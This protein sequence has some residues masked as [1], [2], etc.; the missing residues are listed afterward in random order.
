M[1]EARW[2]D[3][4]FGL[5]SRLLKAIAKL[6]FRSPSEVQKRV[7]PVAMQGK[8][9]LVKAK[10]GSGKTLAFSLPLLN[11]LVSLAGASK[12]S[13]TKGIILAPTKELAKQI[14]VHVMELLYYCKDVIS[15]C[16]LSDNNDKAQRAALMNKPDI[17]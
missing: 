17:V 3:N 5:D 10:T 7:I 4:S 11:K 14:E 12:N 2:T 6:G 13:S 15:V 16:S 9:L 1:A 8:D